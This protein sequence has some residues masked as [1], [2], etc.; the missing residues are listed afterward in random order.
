MTD[1]L[2]TDMSTDMSTEIPADLDLGIDVAV[3]P[4]LEDSEL[5]AVLEALLLVAGSVVGS[6]LLL[7]AIAE[8]ATRRT[9]RRWNTS[10]RS[11]EERADDVD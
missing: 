3:A 6:A 5:G 11:R 1:E 9:L 8:V 2:S 7:W 4:E 10:W